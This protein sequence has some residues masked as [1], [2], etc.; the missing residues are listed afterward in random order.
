MANA[1]FTYGTLKRG[2]CRAGLWPARPLRIQPAWI[3]A[4]LYGRFDY[5]AIT[6]GNDRVSGE[7]WT[8]RKSDVS[9]VI[10]RLDKIEGTNQPGEPDLYLREI[11][12]VWDGD[13]QPIGKAY[14]Y[15]YRTDPLVD[16]FEQIVAE[17]DD[18]T[19]SWSSGL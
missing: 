4:S 5:P 12:D 11:V 8:F 16:G 18:S 1:F 15:F 14:S 17:K 9:S 2:E 6:A 13:D 10:E 3:R 7:L 19:V